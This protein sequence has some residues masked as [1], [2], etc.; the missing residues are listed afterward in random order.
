MSSKILI[1]NGDQLSFYFYEPPPSS[2]LPGL[3]E[4]FGKIIQ[5]RSISKVNILIGEGVNLNTMLFLFTLK[6]EEICRSKG[7]TLE[8][9]IEGENNRQLIEIFKLQYQKISFSQKPSIG[10]R[11][12]GL[13]EKLGRTALNGLDSCKEA[14]KFFLDQISAIAKAVVN[15]RIIRWQ[16]LA[17]ITEQTGSRAMPIVGIMSFLIGLVTA[18]QAAVQLRQF[19]ANIFVADL[20]ALGLSR[21]LSPLITAIL[22]AGRTTSAFAAEI[23]IMKINEELDALKVMNVDETQFLIVPRIMGALLTAPLLTV[24]S[25]FTGLTGAM[26]VAFASL[27]VTPVSFLTEAYEIIKM[28]DL[29]VGFLK[30]ILFGLIIG[31]IG[32]YMGIK[33]AYSPES[34]GRKTTSSVVTTLF[35]IIVADAFVT[36]MA[37]VFHW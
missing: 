28:S 17:Y 5:V 24:W 31:N 3:V 7:I 21:E 26:F 33:T 14:F 11:K 4:S 23:G 2:L 36:V 22:M 8:C 9:I 19:G 20:A 34:V 18:F 25:F 35:L 29:W 10:E 16:E 6:I 37:H 15:P 32:C 12:Y 1:P 27:E 13:I 30:S